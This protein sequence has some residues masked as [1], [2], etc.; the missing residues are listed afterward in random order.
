VVGS[1]ILPIPFILCAPPLTLSGGWSI[2]STNSPFYN[3]QYLAYSQDV[4]IVTVNFRINNFG[5]PGAPGISQNLGLQDQRLAVEWV[6]DNIASFSGD[7][8]KILS[9]GS[10]QAVWQ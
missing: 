4:I 9:S 1:A 5:Y 7:P 6:R 3:G 10:H 8:S 2:G